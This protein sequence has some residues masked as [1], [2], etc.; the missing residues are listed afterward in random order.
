[1][2]LVIVSY[3]LAN[4][5]Y[6]LVLPRDAINSSNT[7]AVLFGSVVFGPVGALVLALVVSATCFGS[8][9]SS[10][11]TAGRLVYVAGKEGYMPALFGRIGTL[12]APPPA[13]DRS[14]CRLARC[15]RRCLGDGDDVG[16]FYT[17]IYALLFNALLTAA[18]C[19]VG[20]FDTLVT[21]YGVAGYSFY[22]LTVLGLIVLRVKEPRLERPYRTWIT[23]PI[24]FCCVSLFL[25]SRAVFARPLQSLSVVA[26]V[27][28]GI[29][30]YYW[31]IGDRDQVG[32]RAASR[33]DAA[34]TSPTSGP[35]WAFW[36]RK[37][38]SRR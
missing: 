36:K 12:A 26:F 13:P 6:F 37:R 28:A 17:P 32:P 10:V 18:Y 5:A 22:F 16:L 1:M 27:L 23:T 25:L 31:R 33:P 19:L 21:F 29:P 20:E 8:L 9:N 11:F 38:P 34:A 4:I 30:I 7:I 3:V 35:W 14:R 15:L 24:I 2:P